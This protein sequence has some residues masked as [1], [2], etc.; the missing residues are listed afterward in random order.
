MGIT[1]AASTA[2]QKG[3]WGGIAKDNRL[4]INAVFWILRSGAAWRDLPSDLGL[5]KRSSAL[6]SVAGQRSLGAPAG[7]FN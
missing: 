3:Q 2:G 4:F 1:D 7:D 5:E 6:L